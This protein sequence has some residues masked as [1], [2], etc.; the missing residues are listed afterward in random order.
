MTDT[1]IVV[2]TKRIFN[3]TGEYKMTKSNRSQLTKCMYYAS[4]GEYGIAA[5]GISSLVRSSRTKK[6]Q[7]EIITEASS[8]PAIVQH[9]DFIIS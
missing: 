8:Y 4:M 3:L 1:S 5:R 2:K 6:E 7:N 9:E